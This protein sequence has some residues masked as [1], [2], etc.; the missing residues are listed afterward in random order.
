MSLFIASA[1]QADTTGVFAVEIAPP[2]VVEGVSLGYCGLVGQFA[3]GPKEQLVT[4]DDALAFLNMFEPPGSPRSSGG[5][6]AIMRRKRLALKVVRV[7]ASG[8]AAAAKTLQDSAPANT[9]ILTAKYHGVLGNSIAYKVEDPTDTQATHFKLTVSLTD[10]VTGTTSEVYDNCDIAAL[11]AVD[12]S[13]SK[14]LASIARTGT[15]LRPANGTGVLTGGSDGSIGSSDYVGTPESADKGI[16]LFERDPD[17]R[18]V[19]ADDCGNSLRPTVNVG[20]A[21]HAVLMG[22]RIAVCQTNPDAADWATVKTAQAASGSLSGDRVRYFGAWASVL[23]DGGVARTVPWATFEAS[24]LVNLEPQ[25]S[26][27]WWDDRV[28]DY[29][30]DVQDVVANFSVIAKTVRKEALSIGIAL[31][32]KLASGRWA[33]QHDRNTNTDP[34]KRYTVRRRVTDY[35]ALTLTRAL[36]SF[37]NGPNV[38]EDAGTIKSLTD[39]ALAAELKKGRITAFSTDTKTLNNSGSMATGLFTVGISATSPAP[40]EK[41]ILNLNVGP[42]VTITEPAAG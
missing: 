20:L 14:L 16:A 15:A 38:D 28:T 42:T 11:T 21:D 41:I 31:P 30:S 6:R 36:P 32:I 39:T 33:I 3:W 9:V 7:L 10:P 23:D 5:Y 18:V 26:S 35:L 27:A 1:D 37:V 17:I 4:P 34:S 19:V 24:A 25:Q 12:V 40:R 2:K 13:A 22:D 8:S 29:Y